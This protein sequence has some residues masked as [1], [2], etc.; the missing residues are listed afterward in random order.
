KGVL[1]TSI[2]GFSSA[3]EVFYVKEFSAYGEIYVTTVDGSC[4][5]K[6]LV[7]DAIAAYK[8]DFDVLYA[9]GPNPMLQALEKSYPHKEAYFSLEI[10][11]GCAVG[12]CLACVCRVQGDETGEQYRKVCKD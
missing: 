4:G 1:V 7:T 8:M 5:Q 10:R 2:L 6:G 12:A 11:M 9:C 3:A